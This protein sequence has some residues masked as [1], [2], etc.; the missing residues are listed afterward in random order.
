MTSYLMD[1]LPICQ[2]HSKQ[3]GR[4]CK[5]FATKG[6]A[7]CHIHGGK[8][9]GAI[10]PKGKIQQKMASWKHGGRSKEMREE[11]L[12]I[13]EMIKHCKRFIAGI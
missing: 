12:H 6:K 7:V 2:A 3:A 8:S 9:T 13:R 1:T 5:N 10:T 4:R 11:S